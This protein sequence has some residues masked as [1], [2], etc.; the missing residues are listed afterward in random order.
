MARRDRVPPTYSYQ[1]ASHPSE[2]DRFNTPSRRDRRS[3]V[4]HHSLYT[5]KKVWYPWQHLPINEAG[6][7]LRIKRIAE[8][9]GKSRTWISKR[10]YQEVRKQKQFG[11]E[12]SAK[13]RE[14]YEA[15]QQQVLR[16]E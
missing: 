4:K 11:R 16:G 5:R 13:L 10:F 8:R 14:I 1:Q 6:V 3:R 2:H 12:S 9:R 7:L 15:M